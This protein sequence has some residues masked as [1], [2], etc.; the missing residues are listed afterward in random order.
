MRWL[1]KWWW[2]LLAIIAIA[3]VIGWEEKH[4][5]TQAE[6]CRAEYSQQARS[7]RSSFWLTPDQ[8][9]AEQEAITAACEPNSY[10]CRFFGA[11]NLPTVFLVF[12]G[13]FGT[14]AA[15]KTLRRMG[16]QVEEMQQQRGVMQGQLDTMKGQL[17]LEHRPWVAVNVEPATP[18]V[19]D[20]RGCVLMCKVTLTNV[21]HSV[22]RQVSLWMD[23]ALL[24]IDNPADVRNKLCDVMKNPQTKVVITAGCFSL[25]KARWNTDR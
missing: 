24:G 3:C 22:A 6:Q 8:H 23:F 17:E 2:L 9:A 5:Q 14:W 4:C 15:L 20:Q 7:D 18:V 13:A 19:F 10:F 25:I 12:I 11:A 1:K 21:G 16:D